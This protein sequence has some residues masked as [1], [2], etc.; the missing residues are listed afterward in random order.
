MECCEQTTCL[1]ATDSEILMNGVTRIL[2][3]EFRTMNVVGVGT[4]EEVLAVMYERN[5]DLLIIGKLTLGF[6]IEK[7]TAEL[8]KIN[9]CLRIL[10]ICLMKCA[11]H[12]G[13]RMYRAG[14]KGMFID[15]AYELKFKECVRRLLNGKISFPEEITEGIKNREHIHN[16]E[17]N[18]RITGRE[19]EVLMTMMDGST[20]KQASDRMHIAV[21]TLSAMRSRILRKLGAES[22]ADAIVIALQYGIGKRLG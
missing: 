15:S 12:F 1:I 17:L 9:P 2:K 8:M 10:C 11:K 13:L 21:G 22:F 6:D 16:A 14:I 4:F 7:R 18:G 3:D 19:M 20:L 5:V